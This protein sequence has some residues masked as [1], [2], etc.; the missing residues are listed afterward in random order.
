MG[1]YALPYRGQLFEIAAIHQYLALN[2]QRLNEPYEAV[3]ESRRMQ[4]NFN[5]WQRNRFTKYHSDGSFHFLSALGYAIINEFGNAK[6]SLNYSQKAF[7]QNKTSLPS[8]L[9]GYVAKPSNLSPPKNLGRVVIIG[10]AGKGPV[11]T[12][13]NWS[14]SYTPNGI[15]S[16]YFSGPNGRGSYDVSSHLIVSAYYSNSQGSRKLNNSLWETNYFSF[17]MPTLLVPPSVTQYFDVVVNGA[18]YS[19]RT[20]ILTDYAILA[21]QDFRGKKAGYFILKR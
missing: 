7:A 20:E 6:V 17:S 21:Q 11:L 13:Q 15:T 19:R 4:L 8:F 5:D 2:Y 14:G 12:E 3:V 10:Y 9:Y 1:D 16:F 18:S